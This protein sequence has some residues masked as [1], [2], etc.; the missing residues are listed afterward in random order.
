MVLCL[1]AFEYCLSLVVIYFNWAGFVLTIVVDTITCRFKL[2][3]GAEIA[4]NGPILVAEGF[5]RKFIFH[6][7]HFL[8]TLAEVRS[9]I[10]SYF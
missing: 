9:L 4:I 6:L 1:C 10:I 2:S 8:S 3:V 7:S 5:R